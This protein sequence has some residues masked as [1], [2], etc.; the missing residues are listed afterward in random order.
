MY[1]GSYD[2]TNH[3]FEI[4]DTQAKQGIHIAP[5]GPEMAKFLYR[6]IEVA[7]AAMDEE[8]KETEG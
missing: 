5:C 6:M 1:T 7:N 2:K 4:M 3:V 8:K